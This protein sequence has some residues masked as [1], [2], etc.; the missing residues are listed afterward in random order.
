M[1]TN[2]ILDRS[3]INYKTGLKRYSL[4]HELTLNHTIILNEHKALTDTFGLT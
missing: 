1:V 3:S 2:A 4:I